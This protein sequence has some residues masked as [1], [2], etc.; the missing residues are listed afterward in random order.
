MGSIL[1]DSRQKKACCMQRKRCMFS[2][3]HATLFLLKS[4]TIDGS[5]FS[6]SVSTHCPKEELDAS[7]SVGHG[8]C[9]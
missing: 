3:S 5:H 4:T 2:V 9:L 8:S 6:V 1:V 7:R